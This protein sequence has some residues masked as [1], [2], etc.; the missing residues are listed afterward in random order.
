MVISGVIRPPPEIRVVADRTAK[1][2]A[3]NGRLFESRI[4]GSAK[5]KTPKF[6]F[7]QPTSPYHAYYEEQIQT[8]TAEE[9][10][11]EI[12]KHEKEK[13]PTKNQGST[14]TQETEKT[15]KQTDDDDP[16]QT[17]VTAKGAATT[18]NKNNINNNTKKQKKDV[19]AVKQKAIRVLDPISKSILTQRSKIA[20]YYKQKKKLNKVSTA[21]ATVTA[22]IAVDGTTTTTTTNTNINATTIDDDTA[23]NSSSDNNDNTT[24]ATINSNIPASSSLSLVPPAPLES[25]YVVAPYN[26]TTTQIETIQLVAQFVAMDGRS[27]SGGGRGQGY[28]GG[29]G[30]AFL[31]ALT[32]REWTNPMFGFCQ[33]RHIHFPYFSALIDSYRKV[34]RDYTTPN[35]VPRGTNSV[36][37]GGANR[38]EQ[39]QKE[40]EESDETTTMLTA[41]NMTM[42]P[43]YDA[44]DVLNDAAYRTEYDRD[45]ERRYLKQQQQQQHDATAGGGLVLEDGEIVSATIIDWHDFVVVELIDFPREEQID[46]ELSMKP[47]LKKTAAITATTIM[48]VNNNSAVTSAAA[49]TDPTT[50]SADAMEESS[51]DE[52]EDDDDDEE[53]TIRVVPSYTPKVVGTYDPSTARAVDP[54]TGKSVAVGDM[55]EHMRIQ[56]LDPKWAEERK[57]FQNKQKDSNLVGG[58]AVVANIATIFSSSASG[59]GTSATTRNNNNNSTT[60]NTGAAIVPTPQRTNA[61]I[62][63]ASQILPPPPPSASSQQLQS[64]IISPGLGV[65]NAANLLP[66]PSFSGGGTT[67]NDPRRRMEQQ[68]HDLTTTTTTTSEAGVK[69]VTTDGNE[70]PPTKKPRTDDATAIP[71]DPRLPAAVAVSPQL[72]PELLQQEHKVTVA[73]IPPS[74]DPA[75]NSSTTTIPLPSAAADAASAAA[76]VEVVAAATTTDEQEVEE[77]VL[78]SAADFIASLGD[79]PVVEIQVRIPNDPTQQ[80][81]NFFGQ[82]VSLT[83]IDVTVT[84]KQLKNIVSKDH[85]NGMPSNKIQLKE[86]TNNQSGGSS[87]KFLSNNTT[88]AALNIGPTATLELKTKQ[89]GGRK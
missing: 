37:V 52:Q 4:L 5:G 55:P 16:K 81:W 44:N 21:T 73:P 18:T 86:C 79:E 88:L 50:V 51:E 47:T 82:T 38:K 58:D 84:V 23:K 28:G 8:Y 71:S 54:I 26:I 89:R 62:T 6:A 83:K 46:I 13:D 2:V 72:P 29:G 64:S 1:Y 10:L 70:E 45:L 24:T 80:N 31:S 61:R 3:K 87:G 48:D 77:K 74:N 33:P 57:K 65:N 30:G 20:D 59:T 69:V 9:E 25:V 60:T 56:L 78:V 14:S 27:S 32:T 76:A 41:G 49:V 34:I 35:V 22:P 53:E 7:L 66:P 85:L 11:Q 67:N 75:E 63:T 40:K 36:L 39:K 43:N 19:V 12:E 15:T 68:Q 17:A 42:N